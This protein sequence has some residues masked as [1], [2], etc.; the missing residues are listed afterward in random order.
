M[1]SVLSFFNVLRT[2]NNAV[3]I[4]AIRKSRSRVIFIGNGKMVF[5]TIKKHGT[6]FEFRLCFPELGV[7][8]SGARKRE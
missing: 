6:E 2:A 5:F 1:L 3:A 8:G 4:N 7:L